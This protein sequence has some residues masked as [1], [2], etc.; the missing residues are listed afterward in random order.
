ML[1]STHEPSWMNQ[2]LR[3]FRKSVR[4]FF[5]TEFVPQQARWREQHRPDAEAW[6]A[7][8]AIGLLLPDIPEEYGGA[9]GSFAHEAVVM[10]ELARAGVHFATHVHNIVAHYI[11]AYGKQEQKCNW[12][13]RMARGELIGA[14]AITEPAAGSDMQGIKTTARRDGDCYVINGSKTFVTNGWHANLICV[15]V[16]TDPKAAGFK[17]MSLLIVETKDLPGYRIGQPLEKVGMH[18][19][20]TCEIF[21]DDVR[22]PASNLLGSAEGKGF[23]Q[24][25]EQLPR[26]RVAISVSAVA[27]AEQA[28][29]IT[30]KYVKERIVFGKSLIDFQ[31][32]RF[33]LAECMTEARIG[34]VFVDDCVERFIA[35][36]LDATTAAMAKYWLTDCQ[37]RIVDECVQLHGGYGYMAE[38]PIARMWADSRVQRIYSGTNEIMK[39]VIATTL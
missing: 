13:P 39:E 23:G 18:G 1:S 37:C 9:G 27:T 26:E 31:N 3:M 17:S 6:N 11:L 10:E 32:T 30:S 4:E 33:K 7:A 14:I 5:Q 20:D 12:L 16:K 35:G 15:A 28:V 25:M 36:K 8:G 34:R 38:Y 21:F 19:Q 22:V 2:D 24:L 29:A